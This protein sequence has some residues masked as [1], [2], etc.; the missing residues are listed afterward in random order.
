MIEIYKTDSMIEV[1][2]KSPVAPSFLGDR[3]FPT[4]DR[5]I[6]TTP[7]VWIER[8]DNGKKSAPFVIPYSGSKLMERE[9]YTGEQMTPVWINPAR[10]M[11]IHTLLK[12][13]I[14][15]TVYD[16]NN[17]EERE[18]QYLTDDM[19]YLESSIT[20]SQEWMRGKILT[21]GYVDCVIGNSASEANKTVRLQFFDESFQNLMTFSTSWKEG[22][23]K[24]EQIS[25]MANDIDA[26]YGSLDLILG[27]NLVG[28][29]LTDET[30]LKL[31]DTGNANFG[32]LNL[33]ET[34]PDGVGYI[35]RMNFGGRNVNIMSYNAT[36]ID[37]TGKPD[38]YIDP[39][40]MV[41]LPSSGFGAT[42]YGAVTQME[43][44][45]QFHTRTGQFIPRTITNIEGNQRKLEMASACLPHPYFWDSWRVAKP[46]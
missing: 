42:K 28:A 2:K 40:A 33:G 16:E 1:I 4:S 26:E 21:Q 15:K 25:E 11:T 19:A 30:I 6:F 29:F 10:D 17:A 31:L 44:D 20:R 39:D 12:K 46:L 36:V 22:G 24:Y 3:Y 9:A 27:Q 14:G 23:N 18:Q 38:H 7:Q 34:L 45:N 37:P 13:G 32:A 8:A 43:E 5:D 35:G 41:M